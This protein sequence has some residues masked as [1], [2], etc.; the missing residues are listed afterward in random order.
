MQCLNSK[1]EV[2]NNTAIESRLDKALELSGHGHISNSARDAALTLSYLRK[3]RKVNI[4]K[5]IDERLPKCIIALYA[6]LREAWNTAAD[7]EDKRDKIQA[8][9]LAKEC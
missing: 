2:I 6:I 7:A 9:S 3:Q 5:Y 8:L 4:E 1:A